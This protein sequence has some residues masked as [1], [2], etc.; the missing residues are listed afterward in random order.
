[1]IQI[2]EE[3]MSDWPVYAFTLKEI[4]ENLGFIEDENGRFSIELDNDI[5]KAY[6][7][8]LED[9]GM[10]YGVNEEFVSCTDK[11]I[12]EVDSVKDEKLKVFN[13]FR[14][15]VGKSWKGQEEQ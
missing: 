3:V 14:E 1:M 13:L 10:G 8:L 5:L 7:R 6:P 12:Y 2:N 4:L 9:D 11:E 15:K